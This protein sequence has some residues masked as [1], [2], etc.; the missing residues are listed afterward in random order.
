MALFLLSEVPLYR[1]LRFR[2][3]AKRFGRTN[4]S[5]S[6]VDLDLLSGTTSR[7]SR[8]V[9]LNIMPVNSKPSFASPA[10]VVVFEDAHLAGNVFSAPFASS[11]IS[12]PDMLPGPKGE[13]WDESGQTVSFVVNI[14]TGGS[15][16]AQQPTISAAGILNFTLAEHQSG[17][18]S[19]SLRLVD[20]GG[21]A[22]GGA[23]T[24]DPTVL[25]IVVRPLNDAP[26]FSISC[27]APVAEGVLA[28]SAACNAGGVEGCAVQVTNH[29][30]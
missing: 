30:P 6:L 22:M 28:C 24:S 20:S 9:P 10:S 13:L 25:T 19:F 16:F 11:I 4:I 8:V 14:L 5:V 7:T 1:S 21:S 23:D 26:L 18:A 12:G 15:I 27:D 29:N 17:N 3:G 2:T